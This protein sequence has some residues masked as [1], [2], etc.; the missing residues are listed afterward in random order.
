[1]KLFPYNK[2][3]ILSYIND[4]FYRFTRILDFS[5]RSTT[6][7][8]K[9]HSNIYPKLSIDLAY[10]LNKIKEHTFTILFPLSHQPLPLP[11][12]Y[13]KLNMNSSRSQQNWI[14]TLHF[15]TK[16]YPFK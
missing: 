16:N 1:M 4:L 10:N 12:S 3:Q 5:D 11:N 14:F 13:T 7:F 2:F 15:K 6:R 8:V 9:L